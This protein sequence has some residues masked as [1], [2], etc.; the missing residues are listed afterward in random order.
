MAYHGAAGSRGS[1][2]LAFVL[3]SRW[4]DGGTWRRELE[5]A[6]PE[7]D[8]RVWPEIG[9]AGDVTMIAIDYDDISAEVL[10]AFPGLRCIVYLGH[11]AGDLL[12]HPACPPG[13]AVARLKDPG[14]IGAMVEYVILY[15][16]RDL[17]FERLYRE[18][19]RQRVWRLHEPR[20]AREV[21]V[22]VMGLGSVGSAVASALAGLRFR[23]SGWARGPHEL[24]GV[25]CLHGDGALPAFLGD[26]DYCVCVLPLTPATRDLVDRG[27]IGTMKPGAHFMNIGRGA[28]V[29]EEDLLAALDDGRLSGAT[30]DVFR[31]EPL[32]PDH[33]FWSHP[34]VMVTPHESAARLD[35]SLP[36]IAENWRRLVEG[37]PLINL[38]DR[39]R[40]Y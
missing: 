2:T 38:V 4:E 17:R 31:T 19:Q 12:D 39:A 14:L 32:P 18:Q 35:G 8:F 15:L 6:A 34:K 36:A 3:C 11:G 28:V 37:R 22:G 30:L 9:D 13:V 24:E 23:V 1:A 29:V 25:T 16:L 20:L 33:P 40:G 26:L 5:A 10:G 27:T 21:H 7:I